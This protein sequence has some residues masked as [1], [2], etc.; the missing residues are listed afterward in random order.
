[1]QS[2]GKTSFKNAI[3]VSALAAGIFLGSASVAHAQAAE[4]GQA[5]FQQ[6]CGMCHNMAKNGIGPNLSGV[7]GRKAGKAAGFAYS[8]ALAKSGLTW[9]RAKLDAFLAA[10]QSVVPRTR[11]PIMTPDAGQRK[12]IISFLANRK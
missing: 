1:M 11:M 2:I 8:P 3:A 4:S 6:H 12:S 7:V 9:T 5:V 10:P